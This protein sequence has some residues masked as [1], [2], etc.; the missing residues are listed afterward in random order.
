MEG[1]DI[2][3]LIIVSPLDSNWHPNC[4]ADLLAWIAQNAGVS[5]L[6]HYLDDYLTMGPPASTVCQN[7][8]SIFLSLCAELGVPLA[9]DKLEGPSTSLSFLGI[10]LDT[11]RME[12]RLPPNKLIRMQELLTTWLLRKKV[13]KREILSLVGTLQHA[14][15]IV[16][17]GRTFVSRMYASAAK[18]CEM[19][20]I[21]RLNKAF[22]SDLF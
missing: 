15:K 5:Y 8:V 9:T 13:R 10:I 16:W 11:N 21:T 4:L 17:P 22:R 18:L 14:T 20:Y 2:H 6:I 7:N 12:I 3:T 19:H 1:S